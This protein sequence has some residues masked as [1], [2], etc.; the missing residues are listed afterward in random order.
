M[1]GFADLTDVTLQPMQVV[2]PVAKLATNASDAI[3]WPNLQP[4]QEVSL[5]SILNYLVERFTQVVKSIPGVRC[6]SGNV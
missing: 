1:R 3:W 2:H 6:A 5:K 4:I